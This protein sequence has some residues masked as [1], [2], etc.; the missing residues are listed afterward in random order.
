LEDLELDVRGENGD[1]LAVTPPSFRGDLERE[2]DLIEEVVRLDGYE[3]IPITLP[4]SPPSSGVK[5]RALLLEKKA[6]DVLIHHGYHEVITY[7]FAS[8][9]SGDLIG[10]MLDDERRRYIK[11]L[12]PLTED[13]SVLRT[14]LIPGLM[15]TAR[16]NLSWKNSN[17]KLFEL[18]KVFIPQGGFGHRV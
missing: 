11:I 6:I 2:I 16:Y 18:R 10:L 15:E 17:L 12:N 9:A 7:S 14:T 8:P 3:K 13:F 5:N 4:K 1:I